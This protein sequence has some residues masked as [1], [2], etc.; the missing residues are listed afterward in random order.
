MNSRRKRRE[1]D[2]V[3]NLGRPCVG[4]DV[5][6]R[7]S[8]LLG[9][10]TRDDVR[11]FEPSPCEHSQRARCPWRLK[12]VVEKPRKLHLCV[13]HVSLAIAGRNRHPASSRQPQK[14]QGSAD[15]ESSQMTQYQHLHGRLFHTHLGQILF[16]SGLN[17]ELRLSVY[18]KSI[19]SHHFPKQQCR[20]K[21][22]LGPKEELLL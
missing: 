8:S 15:H 21:K 22:K 5:P 2:S 4:R 10:H 20:G 1:A 6:H 13:R 19:L 16:T 9:V 18:Y 12:Q 7:H 3:D 14:L 17:F 11:S